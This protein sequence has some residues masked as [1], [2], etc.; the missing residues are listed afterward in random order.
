[1]SK[2]QILS[3]ILYHIEYSSDYTGASAG[4][5]TLSIAYLTYS[6]SQYSLYMQEQLFKPCQ[7]HHHQV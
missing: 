7:E 6:T 2:S 5:P 1:M 3:S 4:Y